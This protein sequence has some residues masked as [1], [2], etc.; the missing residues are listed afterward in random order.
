M[1]EIEASSAVLLWSRLLEA[2]AARVPEQTLTTWIRPLSPQRLEG[3]LLFI[4]APSTFHR[5][6]FEGH[7]SKSM[8]VTLHEL[9][10]EEVRL[11]VV[12]IANTEDAEKQT[13]AGQIL[14]GKK[15]SEDINAAPK[16]RTESDSRPSE[17]VFESRLNHRYLFENFIEGDSNSFA[18]AA[19]LAIADTSRRSPWNP[20]LI[21]GG[22]GLGKTHLLQ[23]IGNHVVKR[24]PRMRV[25]YASS[26]KFTQDFIESVKNRATTD[27]SQYYRSIDLLLVDDIQFFA[28]KE[29][30]QTEFFHAFNTLYQNGKR[31]VLTSDRPVSELAGF[32]ERLISRFGSGLV[33]NIDPPDY[34]TRVAILKERAEEDIF[35]LSNEIADLIATHITNNVRE[36]E[37]VFVTLMARCQLSKL[38]PTMELVRDIIRDKTGQAG[39]RPPVEKIQ[40][41]VADYF[42]VSVES[43]RGKSRKKEIV[44]ARMVAMTLMTE[45]TDHSLKTIGNFFGGRDHSTV[46]HARDT[47]NELREKKEATIIDIFQS[48]ERKLSLSTLRGSNGG[49]V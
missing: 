38:P 44:F 12:V 1:L 49:Y 47:I 43:L 16:V 32:D 19:C 24:D 8:E 27:F 28:A 18:R 30:T 33:T 41:V 34:E 25:L 31:I 20:L 21:Y 7:Y 14:H 15:R 23:A 17:S 26:E 35:P 42:R 13:M 40:E 48:L 2:F 46:I 45:L 37:G 3:N 11:R 10:G 6:W 9:C 5:E 22:T 39:G 29:R 36:L 4:S